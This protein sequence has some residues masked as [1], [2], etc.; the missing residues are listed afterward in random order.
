MLASSLP[1][2]FRWFSI[3]LA[4]RGFVAALL[5]D[6]FPAGFHRP[7]ARRP[8]RRFRRGF[9]APLKSVD[10]QVPGIR[11]GFRSSPA[12]RPLVAGSR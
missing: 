8:T 2:R 6:S 5:S 11:R 3:A 1:A 9:V 10:Q 7:L 12:R 4:R